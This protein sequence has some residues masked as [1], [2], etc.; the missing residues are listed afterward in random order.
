MLGKLWRKSGYARMA[1][2]AAIVAVGIGC[3]RYGPYTAKTAPNAFEKTDTLVL[4][5]K[6]LVKSLSVEGQKAEWSPDGRLVARANI[7]NLKK[8][9]QHVQVQTVFKDEAG[10]SA[11]DE[12]DWKTMILSPNATDTYQAIASNSAS[13]GYTIRV[14]KAR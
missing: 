6:A 9:M 2:L 3:S 14:R 7:R 8:K 4:L 10:M 5:D 12:T 13:T 11:G 1:L